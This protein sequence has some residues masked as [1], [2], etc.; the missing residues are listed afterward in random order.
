M[1]SLISIVNVV[2]TGKENYK[3]WYRNIKSTLIF[4]NLWKGI[5]EI[6][7]VC[8]SGITEEEVES[9]FEYVSSESKSNSRKPSNRPPIPKSNKDCAIWEDKDRKTHVMI[10]TTVSKE[11]SCHIASINDSYSALK[12]LN[13]LY[14]HCKTHTLNWNLYN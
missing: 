2:S 6:A 3:E 5:C 13:D 8:D 1:H 11:V 7:I 10:S 4:N 12:R 14:I 9:C